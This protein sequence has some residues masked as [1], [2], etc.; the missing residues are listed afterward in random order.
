MKENNPLLQCGEFPLFDRI[1]VS[2]YLP[3]FEQ[4]IA[5][6]KLELEVIANQPEPP[7]FENTVMA[8]DR[9]GEMYR[10][11]ASLFFNLLEAEASE[12]MQNVAEQIIPLTVAFENDYYAN[13]ALFRRVAT[14]YDQKPV[15][16]LREDE[17]M[18]LDEIY[19]SFVRHGA[20]LQ[21]K[22][23]ERFQAIR[24]ELEE[25]ALQYKNHVLAAT[26]SFGL[27]VPRERKVELEGLPDSELEIA[28]ERAQRKG[29]QEGYL[30][31]LSLPSYTAFMKYVGDA[32]LREQMYKAY[33]SR[34][35]GGDDDNRSLV[36]E[37]VNL[38]L[39][40]A[41]LLGYET[42][43]DYQLEQ[44]MLKT[45]AE[46]QGFLDRLISDF[47]PL[48]EKE[49][50]EIGDGCQP[51]DWAFLQQRYQ[52]E[53][54]DFN[55][56]A[57]RD[58]FPLE[59]V[60]QAV[61]ALAGRLY[62]LQ[63][64]QRADIPCYHPQ[65]EV[66]EV[67]EEEG[68]VLALLYMDFYPRDSKRNGAWM[69][70]FRDSYENA[71]GKR[72]IPWVSLVFNFTPSTAQRPSLLTFREVQTL[73]HEFGHGLHAILS[74]V[75]FQTLS[76]TSVARDFVEL[77]SQIMEHWAVERDFLKLFAIHYQTGEPLPES[78]LEKLRQMEHFCIGYATMRQLNF[79]QLDMAWHTIRQP[80][81]GEVE[82]FEIQ[83]TDRTRMLPVVP[84]T[85][86]STSFTH[87]FGGGYAAG[88]YGYKWAEVLSEDA[89]GEFIQE[90]VFSKAVAAR[91]REEILSKGGT[92]DP[93]ELYVRFKGRRPDVGALLRQAMQNPLPQQADEP[94]D[95]A[96]AFRP[97]P[98]LHQ[99][100]YYETDKMAVAHHSNYIRWMEEARVDLLEKIGF[101][102]DKMEAMGVVSPVF[103]VQ[104]A[105]KRPCRFNDMVRIETRMVRYTGVRFVI[106][107]K[108]TLLENGKLLAEGET[109][110]CFVGTDGRPVMIGR[111][112]P[113]IDAVLKRLSAEQ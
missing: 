10:Q 59:R 67:R 61:F 24:L 41:R 31:D 17:G 112:Y 100:K 39:E 68:T 52:S 8:I 56:Q 38:R 113:E 90:G 6:A 98:Y 80:F 89:Y 11:V 83:A 94:S 34:A 32:M 88:Y 92:A 110:H 109:E 45:P 33:N 42:F 35:L 70:T 93:M 7:D 79:G 76:G 26:A 28:A 108:M 29:K 54:L 73:L 63:F 97:E 43:A 12:E 106:A 104:C 23:K 20:C 91:F 101:S 49:I 60:K 71:E 86:I 66:Y 47:K 13:E 58:Y 25:K 84:H 78:W 105:F 99:V 82:D 18:L 21:G 14:L 46:V 64:I 74:R 2:D 5:A 96:C 15:L 27:F 50:K 3:A 55:E 36:R 16:T 37:M 95:V 103:S 69:T 19:K 4:A 51:W 48:A 40:M 75:R 81:G 53:K 107:Y 72:V 65:V 85:G 22:E 1:S 9:A 30:F 57:V 62:G 111:L 77:P 44:R 87:I 102:Y